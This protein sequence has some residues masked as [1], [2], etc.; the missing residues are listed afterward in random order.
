[1]NF[2]IFDVVDSSFAVREK[3]VNVVLVLN[4]CCFT[5]LSV[6]YFI[7]DQSV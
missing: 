7:G 6:G 4:V 5:S 3:V 1:M 2:F